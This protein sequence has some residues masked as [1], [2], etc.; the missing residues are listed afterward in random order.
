MTESSDEM[1]KWIK[2]MRYCLIVM[3]F[4]VIAKIILLLLKLKVI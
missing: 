3:V 4:C 1:E 2:I